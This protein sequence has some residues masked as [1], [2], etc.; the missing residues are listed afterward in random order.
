MRLFIFARHAESAANTA[1]VMSSDPGRRVGLS[2]R[3]RQQAQFLAEQL[4]YLQID[5]AVCS[6]F[7]RTRQTT[8]LAIDDRR[9]PL[10][11]DADL[12]EVDAGIFDGRP[13]TDYWEW[14]EQH[15]LTDRFPGG[16]SL[17]AARGRYGA[18]IRRLLERREQTTLIVCHELALRLILGAAHNTSQRR[19]HSEVPNAIPYLLDELALWR[20]LRHF[21]ESEPPGAPQLDAAA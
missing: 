2:R 1:H 21:H 13:I 11:I 4:A 9:I 12:N 10:R 17:E 18:A 8:E 3:G 5:E 15:R 19:P 16:E 7:L 14:K 6:Q 20:A